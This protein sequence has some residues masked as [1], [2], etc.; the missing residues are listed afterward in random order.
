MDFFGTWAGII[1]LKFILAESANNCTVELNWKLALSL[2]YQLL[3]QYS[4]WMALYSQS[5][6]CLHIRLT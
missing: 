5:L 6:F 2:L 1:S 4:L 3:F